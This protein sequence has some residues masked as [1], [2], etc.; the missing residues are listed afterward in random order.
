MNAEINNKFNN[1]SNLNAEMKVGGILTGM[2][3]LNE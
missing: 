3:H 1:N 2:D